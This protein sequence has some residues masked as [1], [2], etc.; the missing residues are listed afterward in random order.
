MPLLLGQ[1]R[2]RFTASSRL[3][4]TEERPLLSRWLQ[5][6]LCAQGWIV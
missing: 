3:R 4:C 2:V 6:M 1:K 5:L